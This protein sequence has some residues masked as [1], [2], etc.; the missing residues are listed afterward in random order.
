MV[1]TES[2][3][4]AQTGLELTEIHLLSDAGIRSM[5]HHTQLHSLLKIVLILFVCVRV[6]IYMHMCVCACVCARV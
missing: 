1:E 3:Y 6:C 5:C 4:V 2:L